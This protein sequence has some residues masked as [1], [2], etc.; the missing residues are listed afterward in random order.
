VSSAS[1][2]TLWVPSAWLAG[3]LSRRELRSPN[4]FI[5]TAA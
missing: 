3:G 5:R 2:S 4:L 1:T